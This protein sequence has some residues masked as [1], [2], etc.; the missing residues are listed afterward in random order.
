MVKNPRNIRLPFRPQGPCSNYLKLPFFKSKLIRQILFSFLEEG[1]FTKINMSDIY[2]GEAAKTH[3]IL[4]NQYEAELLKEFLNEYGVSAAQVLNP[5]LNFAV[6]W[7]DQYLTTYMRTYTPKR[8]RVNTFVSPTRMVTVDTDVSVFLEP[9]N[10]DVVNKVVGSNVNKSVKS[11]VNKVVKSEHDKKAVKPTYVKPTVNVAKQ[12]D[13]RFLHQS[14]DGGGLAKSE[15]DSRLLHSVYIGATGS[16]KTSTCV[17]RST[18]VD[19]LQ[20]RADN[21][22]TLKYRPNKRDIVA[23]FG[24]V[25]SSEGIAIKGNAASLI[26]LGQKK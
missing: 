5:L 14:N 1:K 22:E 20:Q 9:D 19:D 3:T 23:N 11:I 17:S 6:T 16:D 7:N 13:T 21:S 26:L 8:T 24:D 2:P 18:T 10:T 25:T 15:K 4:I 12:S